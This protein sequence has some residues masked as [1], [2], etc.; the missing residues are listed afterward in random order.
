MS[1]RS[2]SVEE[3]D[4][5]SSVADENVGPEPGE[6]GADCSVD[7]DCNGYLRC[8]QNACSVP[9]AVTGDHDENTPRLTI[10]SE[11]G[12]EVADFYL[13]LARTDAEQQRGL[14][15]RREMQPDWGMLFVYDRQAQRSFWMKNTFI[16]LDMVFIDASGEVDSIVEGAEPLTR[17]QRRSKG[18]AKYVLELNAGTAEEL[19][20]EPGMQVEFE[21]VE[22]PARERRPGEHNK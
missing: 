8:I 7:G 10:L 3:P 11:D 16:P 15:F 5:E 19:G 20:I 22:A 2:Y 4:Q 6:Q 12:L 1:E 17:V 21:G 18:A 13:E 14:M 9:P